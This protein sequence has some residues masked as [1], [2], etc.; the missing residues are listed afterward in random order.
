[1]G[2]SACKP[3]DT[4][5]CSRVPPEHSAPQR[6]S[7]AA[8]LQRWQ[9][10]WALSLAW[11][12]R[13]CCCKSNP[14][15][16]KKLSDAFYACWCKCSFQSAL[17]CVPTTANVDCDPSGGTSECLLGCNR[18]FANARAG[19]YDA[20]L[21][22]LPFLALPA[23]QNSWHMAYLL[24]LICLPS[25]N[26]DD[27]ITGIRNL[28]TSKRQLENLLTSLVWSSSQQ[29]EAM[30]IHEFTNSSDMQDISEVC[31]PPQAGLLHSSGD[32]AR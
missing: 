1:M 9:C 5:G 29:Q 10:L 15:P 31:I 14:A 4:G 26:V 11:S 32:R 13:C 8:G 20:Q 18:Q 27:A 22:Q 12:C 24:S 3:S 23:C 6:Q 2:S 17:M 19:M 25:Q 30:T 7:L 16:A 28:Q 21:I